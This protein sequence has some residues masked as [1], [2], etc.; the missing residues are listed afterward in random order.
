[1]NPKGTKD[2]NIRLETLRLVQELIDISNDFLYG[3]EKAQQLKE[4]IYKWDYMK[5]KWFCT[6]KEMVTNCRG[7]PKNGRKSLIGRYLTKNENFQ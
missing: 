5:L 1:M 2:L 4:R 6:T 3:T 7:C